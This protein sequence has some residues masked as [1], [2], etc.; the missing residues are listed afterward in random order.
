MEN[1]KVYK[2]GSLSTNRAPER[3]FTGNV[4]ISDYF[5][6]E[7]PSRLAGATVTFPPGA[8]TPW[9]TN[10]LGQTLMITSGL[11]WAQCEGEAVFEVR[12]GDIVQF[13]PEKRHWDGATPNHAMSYI[14]MHEAQG[15]S[16]VRFLEKVTEDE[17]LKGNSI[18][19][20]TINK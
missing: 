10:P 1:V 20:S 19:R 7:N 6:C 16:A 11:G 5:Q 8:R 15:G 12:A 14:A 13:P 9:K 3:N 17:Y 18:S 4:L 2:L